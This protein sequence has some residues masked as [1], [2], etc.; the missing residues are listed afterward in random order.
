MG[1]VSD[2]AFHNVSDTLLPQN[3]ELAKFIREAERVKRVVLTRKLRKYL[4]AK[5]I[6]TVKHRYFKLK[7]LN[8]ILHN[9]TVTIL[10]HM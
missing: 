4:T 5:K 6:L 1:V 3:C 7:A 9:V 8:L 10:L 2:P